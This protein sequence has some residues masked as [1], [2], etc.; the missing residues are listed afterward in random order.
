ML[1]TGL[2]LLL[3]GVPHA[4]PSGGTGS[5]TRSGPAPAAFQDDTVLL[6][7]T[8]TSPPS[9][10]PRLAALAGA[11][12]VRTLGAATH[13]LRVRRG[14]VQRAIAKLRDQPDVRYAEP[15][16]L[17]ATD[18]VPNDPSFGLEWGLQNTGQ[19]VNG[20]KGKVGADVRAPAAWNVTTGSRAVVIAQVDT[21]V[22]YTHPD[23]RD[24]LWSNPGGIGGCPAGTHGYN[25]LKRTCDPMDA[26]GHGT[27][28][29]GIMGAVG[30]NSVGVGGVNWSTTILPVKFA[31][32]TGSGTTS[33]LIT[34]MDWVLAAKAAGVD[35]RVLNDSLTNP[36]DA[37]SQA[38]ADEIARLG[39]N[40]ILFVTAAGNTKQDNDVTPRYPCDYGA[41]NEICVA[42]TD[43][44]DRLAGFSNWGDQTVDLAAPGKNIY[45][46]LP[47]GSYG[48][49]SGTSMAAPFVTGAAAL[50]LSADA[51][52][53]TSQLKAAILNGVDTLPSLAG[54]VRTGGRLDV[55]R[56]L[57]GCRG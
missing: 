57:S 34:A 11:V 36:G 52:M 35:V 45:S 27:H 51:T 14:E 4:S 8:R 44:K 41:A 12:H 17:I 55:C 53:S 49:K 43:Q 5:R 16:Y 29:A 39:R 31:N 2:V 18:A 20:I 15:D 47:N 50:T 38:L 32:R 30:N 9:A 25:V 56:V 26:S 42:A 46:T 33:N 19:T 54:L 37:Y 24:N 28:V 22:D 48:L 1:L 3:T 10:A 6:G 21:G 40:G 13:L 7:L 23:L